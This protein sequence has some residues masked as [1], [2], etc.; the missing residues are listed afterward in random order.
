MLG[1]SANRVQT[2]SEATRRD[3]G[4]IGMLA[5]QAVGTA[6][7]RTQAL[8]REVAGQGPEKTL[9]RGFAVVRAADGRTLT[10][11]ADISGDEAIQVQFNDGT[12]GARTSKGK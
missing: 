1:H 8:M 4:E 7:D 6:A 12:V 3:I 9:G 11:A 2:A 5:R 10:R